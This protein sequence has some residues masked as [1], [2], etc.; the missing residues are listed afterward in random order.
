M[1]GN[2]SMTEGH[3]AVWSALDPKFRELRMK[4]W[5]LML[6]RRVAELDP[7]YRSYPFGRETIVQPLPH[8]RPE[9]V[10]IEEVQQQCSLP[11]KG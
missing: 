4:E 11:W 1:P 2:E 7:N 8:S 10:Q 6:E 9:F 5:A 3:A